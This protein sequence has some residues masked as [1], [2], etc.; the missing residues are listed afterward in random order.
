MTTA[1]QEH[2]HTMLSY[3]LTPGPGVASVAEKATDLPKCGHRS[4][5]SKPR[6]EAYGGTG[7]GGCFMAVLLS[8]QHGDS[9]HMAELLPTTQP[10]T[11]SVQL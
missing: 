5:A 7:G 4:P 11:S 9:T 1:A 6:E 8:E 10:C 3:S 2:T